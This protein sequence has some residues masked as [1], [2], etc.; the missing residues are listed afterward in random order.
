VVDQHALFDALQSQRIAGAGI[1][2][3][4][5]SPAD[6]IVPPAELP[7]GS[8]PNTVL[9]PHHSGHARITFERRAADIAANIRRLAEGQALLNLVPRS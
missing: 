3:W 2:V 8:L 4:W 5:G 7:F 1:D 6:G 9:T